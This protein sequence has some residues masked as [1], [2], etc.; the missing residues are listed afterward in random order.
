MQAAPEP[1][2]AAHVRRAREQVL[3]FLFDFDPGVDRLHGVKGVL[4]HVKGGGLHG[5]K[6]V[7]HHAKGGD[8]EA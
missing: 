1:R 7:L 8:S 3:E 4:H 6:G 2:A 5:V